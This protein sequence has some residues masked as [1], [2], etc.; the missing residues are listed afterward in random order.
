MPDFRWACS[1]EFA[2]FF[3]LTWA[4]KREC[5]VSPKHCGT[6]CRAV[7]VGWDVTV[8]CPPPK[9]KQPKTH[10]LLKNQRKKTSGRKLLC[11]C[12]GLAGDPLNQRYSPQILP[13]ANPKFWFASGS[14]ANDT[15]MSDI[16]TGINV[17]HN[18]PCQIVAN[19]RNWTLSRGES[20]SSVS[21]W[22]VFAD[23]ITISS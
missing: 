19:P 21:V 1:N 8:A 23:N 7:G 12:H 3:S 17:G 16:T 22:H 5:L 14:I 2:S 18:Q 20:R 10:A 15:K 13:A 11:H 9:K 4:S 6:P